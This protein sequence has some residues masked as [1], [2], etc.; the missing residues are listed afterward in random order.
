MV[1]R[2]IYDSLSAL[3][4]ISGVHIADVGTG[5]GLPGIPLALCFPDKN[6]TLLDSNGKKTRFVQHAV[7]AL[8]L[9]NVTVQQARIEEYRPTIAFDAVISRA[10]AS[11]QDFVAGCEHTMAS[12]G[13]LIA[14]KGKFPADELAALKTVQPAWQLTESCEIKVPEL[15]GER[16]ILVLE[17]R[18]SSTTATQ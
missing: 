12:G 4:F 18:D 6:F 16:H 7:N 13:R 11:L 5:A 17:S 3:P 2:H 8:E 14:M 9:S 10:F 1:P 15:E